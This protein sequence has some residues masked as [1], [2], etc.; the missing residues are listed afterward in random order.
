MAKDNKV[1]DI[2]SKESNDWYPIRSN[3]GTSFRCAECY[4]LFFMRNQRDEYANFSDSTHNIQ[5]G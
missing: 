4:E 5:K 1:C 2:C 3:K